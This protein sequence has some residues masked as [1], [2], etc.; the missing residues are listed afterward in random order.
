MNNKRPT[1]I[2]TEDWPESN[3][4]GAYKGIAMILILIGFISFFVIL[5][6]QPSGFTQNISNADVAANGEEN[7]NFKDYWAI[8]GTIGDYAGGIAGTLFSLA[9]FALLYLS[10]KKQTEANVTQLKAYNHD[11]VEG[12]FFELIKL[13]RE[14]V[15]EI[16]FTVSKERV[17]KVF[18]GE[19][20][21]KL[22]Y[23]NYENRHFFVAF[24]DQLRTALNEL[25]Y[26]FDDR[27]EENL[28]EFDYLSKLRANPTLIERKID[29]IKFAKID[30]LYLMI[31]FGVGREGQT[32]IKS[33]VDKKYD[34]NFV[35]K[36]LRTAALKPERG[37]IYY[38][39]WRD[40]QKSNNLSELN[41]ELIKAH[42]GEASE[43]NK[44]N[45][46]LVQGSTYTPFIPYYPNDFEKY[47]GGHQFR[48][49]HYFRHIFHTISFINDNPELSPKEQYGYIKHLRGQ[50]S[51]NEQ[52]LIF[53]NSLSQLGRVWELEDK[54]SSGPII[55]WKQLISDYMLIK[56]IPNDEIFPSFKLSDYYPDITYEGFDISDKI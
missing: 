34:A 9:G 18:R 13:H 33:L 4:E 5:K 41:S 49:G 6:N 25:G 44:R 31:F 10:F 16:K 24:M 29:L 7:T 37:S 35:D 50:F 36:L 28:Y 1:P 8:K 22:D 42:N 14:N 55:R 46:W 38:S 20:F 43:I 52:I 15:S 39:R 11:K 2:A 3:P 19:T 48:L 32:T 23:V 26:L 27:T 53:L 21:T 12:R 47:Y 17:D 45:G 54:K 30:I 56:N 40:N 51:T